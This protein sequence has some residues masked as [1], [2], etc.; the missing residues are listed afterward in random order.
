MKEFVTD[1]NED[2][3]LFVGEVTSYDNRTK[4]FSVFY[5]ADKYTEKVPASEIKDHLDSFEELYSQVSKRG[6]RFT[7]KQ[8]ISIILKTYRQRKF[9]DIVNQSNPVDLTTSA[10]VDAAEEDAPKD[11]KDAEVITKEKMGARIAVMKVAVL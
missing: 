10:D 1:I 4:C 6:Q 9:V 2:I 8:S 5:T 7:R 11:S 3:N